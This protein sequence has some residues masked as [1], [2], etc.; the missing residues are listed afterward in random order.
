MI[1]ATA[2]TAAL[3][4]ALGLRHG[5]DADHLA[6]IDGVTRWNAGARRAFAPYCGALF[7]A[8][9]SSVI[10]AAAV[11]LSIL[12]SQWQP[13]TWIVP[14]GVLVSAL[15]LLLLS[16]INLRVAF[17]D[18]SGHGGRTIGMRSRVFAALL[19]AP[20]PWQVAL[21]GALFAVSFDAIALAG[22]FAASASGAAIGA[23]GLALVFAAGMIA[24]GA[25][26]GFWVARLLRHS[27]EASRQASRIVTLTIALVGI[28]VATC[29]LLT[30]TV[31]P[32]E[33]WFAANELAVSG[34]VVTL[35]LAGYFTALVLSRR[36]A[37]SQNRTV[38]N[39][40]SVRGS[41]G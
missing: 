35:V 28:V 5:L 41:T 2:G 13:P 23:G 9:H 15:T 8:G 39:A 4:F 12:A 20:R 26:N 11:G 6:A 7:S 33:Q 29:A 30:L 10:L 22:L 27:G 40:R 21:L 19:R 36:A 17:D 1:A 14:V 24:V 25:A 32:F 16:A 38:T 34:F 37:R 3:A 31:E 18:S